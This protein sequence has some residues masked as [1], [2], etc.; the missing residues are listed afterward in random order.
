VD[1]KGNWLDP[2][3]GKFVKKQMAWQQV[4][5]VSP[6]QERHSSQYTGHS[7]IRLSTVLFR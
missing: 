4:G 7:R 3:T 5:P 6:A 2:Q 1:E